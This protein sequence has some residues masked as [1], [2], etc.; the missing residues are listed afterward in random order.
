MKFDVIANVAVT[1]VAHPSLFGSAL[2]L[3]HI[4]Q[5]WKRIIYGEIETSAIAQIRVLTK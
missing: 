5:Q 1:I 4:Q 2:C 3:S